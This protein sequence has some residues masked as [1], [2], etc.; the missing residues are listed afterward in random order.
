MKKSFLTIALA[1]ASGLAA[2][3]LG[4]VFLLRLTERLLFGVR[5]GDP[6]SF[7][8]AAAFVLLCA[9]ASAVVPSWRAA[10]IDPSRAL[11]EE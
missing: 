5:P 3:T 11:R 4:A 1:V 9:A 6:W 8:A 7:G 10:R 2:G